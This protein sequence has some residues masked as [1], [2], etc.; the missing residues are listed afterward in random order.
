MTVDNRLTIIIVK[1]NSH[2]FARVAYVTDL[3]RSRVDQC[4]YTCNTILALGRQTMK[5]PSG[6][7]DALQIV[8]SGSFDLLVSSSFPVLR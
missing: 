1:S 4:D 5:L 3:V 8:F 6:L 2:R 7:P